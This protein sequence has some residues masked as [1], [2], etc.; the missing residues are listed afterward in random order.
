MCHCN[1]TTLSSKQQQSTLQTTSRRAVQFKL[2]FDLCKLIEPLKLILP[3][4]FTNDLY[5]AD[6]LTQ[7]TALLHNN[8]ITSDDV[9]GRVGEVPVG[10]KKSDTSD[11]DVM[12]NSMGEPPDQW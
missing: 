11:D 12:L 10:D 2:D 8:D 9:T 7:H 6:S 3:D 1:S 5:I 4:L